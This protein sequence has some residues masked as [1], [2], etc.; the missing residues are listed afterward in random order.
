MTPT[1]KELC[2]LTGEIMNEFPLAKIGLDPLPSGVRFLDVELGRRRFCL[3]YHPTRGTGVSEITSETTP[4][5]SG[6][7]H[8]FNSVLEAAG[9]LKSLLAD[10][11][12]TEVNHMPQVYVP[13]ENVAKRF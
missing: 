4:F 7:D 8:S 6:H 13:K 3:E 12:K 11:A 5:D 9:C 1:P 2:D 10:A